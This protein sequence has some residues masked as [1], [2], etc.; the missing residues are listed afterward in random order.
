MRAR[1]LRSKAARHLPLVA[2]IAV[3]VAAATA[4][5]ARHRRRTFTFL[6]DW[7]SLARKRGLHLG[8]VVTCRAASGRLREHGPTGR[9]AVCAVGVPGLRVPHATQVTSEITG[10]PVG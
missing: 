10:L 2:L 6:N 8:L 3:V 1:T 7:C 4:A 9:M 5:S